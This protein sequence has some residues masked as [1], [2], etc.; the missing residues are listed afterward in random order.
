VVGTPAYMAP[1][2]ATGTG[3]DVR[4]DVHA[5]AAVAYQML[6]GRLARETSIAEL[7]HAVLP[8][9]PSRLADLPPA[10][11]EVLLRALDPDP[12]VRQGSV[13]AFVADL[14]AAAGATPSSLTRWDTPGTVA[15]PAPPRRTSP[16]VLALV[17]VVVFVLAFAAAYAVTRVAR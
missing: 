13:E 16:V 15:A 8:T 3:V 17:S 11:D 7:A 12:G 10:V 9:P 2:Q 6:T 14:R 1:E 5:L 4:A